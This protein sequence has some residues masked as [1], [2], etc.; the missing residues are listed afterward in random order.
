[1]I[2]SKSPNNRISAKKNMSI[3]PPSITELFGIEVPIIQAPM[4]GI[5]T[6]EMIIRVAEAGGLGSLPASH[7]G[8]EEARS[9]FSEIRRRT[10]KPIN[11][12]FLCHQS[13]ERHPA[14]EDAWV[15]RLT[16]YYAEL[17]LASDP[18]PPRILVPAFGNAHCALLEEIAPKV[19]SFHFGLP[20]RPLL[21]RVR[22]TGAKIV[23]SATTVE[24]AQW[25]EEAG[26]DAIIAQGL[27]AGG[28]RGTFLHHNVDAQVGT[29][30]LVPQIVDAVKVPVIAAGGIGDPRGVA[31]AFALGGA[32]AVQIGT[33]F[34]FC[35]EANVSPLYRQAIRTARPEQTLVTNVFTGRP[36]R[37]CETWIVRELGPMAK[38]VP[39][40]PLAAAALAP[41]RAASE[42]QGCTDFMP[43]WCGQ[44][45]GLSPDVSAAELTRWLS[46][47]ACKH[48]P[49]R[50]HEDQAVN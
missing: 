26:C 12:N 10:S 34:L 7:L 11:I 38:N 1:M 28:H 48:R 25:L 18:S 22:K 49:R 15:R 46:S 35:E 4:L 5:V 16:P 45:A 6:A 20:P 9:V 36:A 41:L 8:A 14:C 43:L 47:G 27:E 42:P 3:Y 29:M 17:G 19:V 40:F 33:A 30:A 44:A 21:E 31:A 13:P 37:V 23:S 32:A 24:E 39:A 2:Q 50:T